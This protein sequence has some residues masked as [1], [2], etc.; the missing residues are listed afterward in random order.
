MRLLWYNRVLKSEESINWLILLPCRYAFEILDQDL[1]LSET[2]LNACCEVQSRQPWKG[3]FTSFWIATEGNIFPRR[4]LEK[5]RWVR[6]INT[7]P[8]AESNCRQPLRGYY[9]G[10][11]CRHCFPWKLVHLDAEQFSEGS[12]TFLDCSSGKWRKM[13]L[14]QSRSYGNESIVHGLRALQIQNKCNFL[15]YS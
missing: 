6:V 14:F 8:T 12:C 1:G 9:M 11:V 13:R 7:S 3:V 2:G 5:L 15:Q 10:E 4:C